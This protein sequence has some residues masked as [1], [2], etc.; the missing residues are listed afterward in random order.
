MLR[1]RRDAALLAPRGRY[2]R[3]ACADPPTLPATHPPST[4]GSAPTSL[5]LSAALSPLWPVAP[6]LPP[7][8]RNPGPSSARLGSPP[9]PLA[10]HVGVGPF[11]G[12]GKGGDRGRGGRRGGRSRE[13]GPVESGHGEQSGDGWGEGA[14]QGRDA[15]RGEREWLGAEGGWERTLPGGAG[16]LCGRGQGAP[17]RRPGNEAEA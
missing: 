15:G 4:P 14:G 12:G 8:L 2:A 5:A 10:G 3:Q 7:R 1:R 13:G 11:W 16:R 17:L 9:R 6:S